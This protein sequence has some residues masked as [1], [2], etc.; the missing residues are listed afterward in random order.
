[1]ELGGLEV[2]NR[3]NQYREGYARSLK[4]KRVEWDK[5]ENVQHM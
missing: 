1:M 4:G 3:E 5:E 2:R